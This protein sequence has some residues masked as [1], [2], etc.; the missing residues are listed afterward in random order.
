MAYDSDPKKSDS[1]K[2]WEN[3]FDT[4]RARISNYPLVRPKDLIVNL[5]DNKRY[6]I[7]HVETT[8]LP[9][10]SENVSVLSKQNYIVSQLLTLEELNTDDNEYSID[11]DNIPEVPIEDEGETGGVVPGY[12]NKRYYG[13]NAN[14]S[15]SNSEILALNKENCTA[16]PNTHDYDCSGGKY[17]WI[18]YPA[19]FG[20]AKFSVGGFETTF[21]LTVKSVTNDEAYTESYNCYRSFRLQHGDTIT[22]AVL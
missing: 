22:V 21:D 6:V 1:Q 5:D 3:T 16:R 15:L 19:R 8:K 13:A 20:L 9:K 7:M 18:C 4:K 10:I 17:I 11:I 14:T 12:I 2:E